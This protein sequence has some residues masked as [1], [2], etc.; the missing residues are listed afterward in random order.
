MSIPGFPQKRRWPWIAGA[1]AVVVL[2]GLGVW[3]GTSLQQGTPTRPTGQSS[4]PVSTD[5]PTDPSTPS[6]T[7]PPAAGG[8]D[9][10]LG[11]DARTIDMLVAARAAAPNT[12]D[13]AISFG[14][15]YLRWL[16]Q[17]PAV[18][19]ADIKVAEQFVSKVDLRAD[20][21]SWNEAPIDKFGKVFYTSTVNG[22]YRV[23]SMA[24]DH[25]DVSYLLRAVRDGAVDPSNVMFT[26]VSLDWDG[27]GWT[28]TGEPDGADSKTMRQTGTA[29][30]GGC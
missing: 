15:T 8:V 22:F 13:G 24:D 17:K 29:F 26:T 25:V 16:G 11:G 9:A 23:E 12:V 5:A 2:I 1:I 7:A 27:T 14:A 20:A 6:P 19:E 18:S 30:T 21:A 10:C 3:I 28:V 4:P